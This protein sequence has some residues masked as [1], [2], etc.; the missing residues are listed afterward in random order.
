MTHKL[1]KTDNYLL[2][3]DESE[4]KEGDCGYNGNMW[5]VTH[6]GKESNESFGLMYAKEYGLDKLGYGKTILTLPKNLKKAIAHLPLNNSPILEGV[7][8][9]PPLED[10]VEKLA[11]QEY[12][13]FPNNPKDKPDWHYNRD[14]NC[15]RKRKAFVKGYNTAKEKYKYTEED[16]DKAYWAGMK[17]VGE[18]KGSYKEFIQSLQQPKYP[19]EF[20]SEDE[21]YMYSI[22]G[23]IMK[24]KT[25]TNSQGQT[26]LVGTYK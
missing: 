12:R 9:L 13:E 23:D 8:L 19:V 2:V 16:I 10:E 5:K 4:I 3:V 17:F 21:V 25:T 26:V 24:P 22:N 20:E 11:E 14:I 7:P 6:I 15:F 1:I 18:D